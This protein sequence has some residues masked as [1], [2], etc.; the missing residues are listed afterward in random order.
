LEAVCGEIE[1]KRKKR[2]WIT[3]YLYKG[4]T[5]VNIIPYFKECG[6]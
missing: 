4:V 2:M 6:K 1:K 3:R 5:R